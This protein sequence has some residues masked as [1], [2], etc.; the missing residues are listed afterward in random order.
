MSSD[1]PIILLGRHGAGKDT[2]AH[3]L[4]VIYNGVYN[5]KFSE[6]SKRFV[7]SALDIPVSYLND[8]VK[9]EEISATG[10]FGFT[11]DLTA[12]DM[13]N[14]LFHGS[15]SD[16]PE[17]KRFC[18]AGIRFVLGKSE[19]YPRVVFT[20][21]RR[22][23]EAKAVLQYYEK[24]TVVVLVDEDA[25]GILP[26]PSDENLPALI[27]MLYENERVDIHAL[28]RQTTDTPSDTF[29]KLQTLIN[30]RHN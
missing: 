14:V 28:N 15:L 21:I 5:A 12:L 13:L 26:E 25:L 24:V 16:T 3:L 20:D 17:A 29:V 30:W 19:F 6:F 4:S 9:R 22:L 10:T 7:S 23:Q 27:A 11:S 8:R 18:E 2:M 1:N